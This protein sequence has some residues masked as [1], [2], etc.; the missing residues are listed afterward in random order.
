M[1][2]APDNAITLRTEA[3][4]LWEKE[5]YDEDSKR[6]LAE[7]VECT[8]GFRGNLGDLLCDPDDDSGIANNFWCPQCTTK[9]W[10]WS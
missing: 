6:L 3:E 9:G 7:P 10:C 4:T 1:M 8:C 2:A 5:S